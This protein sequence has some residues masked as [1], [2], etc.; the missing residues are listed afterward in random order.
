[1][2]QRIESFF[3]FKLHNTSFKNEIVGGVTTFFTLAYVI[4]LNPKI[5]SAAGI[6][7][8]AAM[9]ASVYS[10][11]IG[12]L[13]MAFYAKK[14]FAIAPFVGENAFI[15]YTI[16]NTLGYSWQTALGAIFISGIILLLLTVTGVREKI[17]YAIPVPMK[18]SFAAGIG[19]FLTFVGLRDI[20]IIKPDAV[21]FVSIAAPND[22]GIVLGIIGIIAT[23]VMLIKRVPGAML[24]SIIGLLL[25]GLITGKVQ[26]PETF[27]SL[28][29]SIAETLFKVD[30]AGALSFEFLPIFLTLFITVFVDTIGTLSAL[31]VKIGMV[32]S[33]GNLKDIN[34]PLLADAITTSLSALMGSVTNGVYIESATG[35][36]A[37]ARTGFASVITAVLFFLTLFFVPIV[38]IIPPF[39]Y[40]AAL[41][42]VGF[43]MFSAIS[44][45]KLEDITESFPV[46]AV[47]FTM[48]FTLNIGMGM[49]AGF[50]VYPLLKTLTGR[51]TEVKLGMWILMVLSVVFFIFYPY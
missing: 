8:D 13:I 38:Q 19:L 30:I 51:F 20:G 29:P 1:M 21:S 25:A 41:V 36:Q 40:G 2:K 46:F 4:I 16:C 32:D 17:A 43:F 24:I 14:P 44:G 9:A 37:G 10:A 22:L 42:M 27:L 11:V 7:F 26:V 18:I 3:D 23:T 48:V 6:P 45:L 12:T 47:L 5:L 31:A 49:A 33:D 28:P 39:A 50:T 15:S 35:Y 34:K